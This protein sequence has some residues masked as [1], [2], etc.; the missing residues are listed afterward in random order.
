MMADCAD[1]QRGN[2]GQFT[3]G[4]KSISRKSTDFPGTVK[5]EQDGRNRGKEKNGQS[6]FPG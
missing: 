2:L 3:A 6:D 4:A 5:G 1:Q